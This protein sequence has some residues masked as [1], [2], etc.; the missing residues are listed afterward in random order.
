MSLFMFFIADDVS[1]VI[2][3]NAHLH[4]FSKWSKE[5]EEIVV[6]T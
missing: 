2:V 5:G 6:S 3:A 1:I 4:N